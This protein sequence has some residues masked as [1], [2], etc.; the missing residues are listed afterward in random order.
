MY[1]YMNTYS[2]VSICTPAEYAVIEVKGGVKDTGSSS[3]WERQ[4]SM[5]L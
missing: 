4:G 3:I 1:I 5:G 2:Y